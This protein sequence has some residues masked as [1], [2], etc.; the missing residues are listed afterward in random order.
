M[1]LH[2]LNSSSANRQGPSTRS[3]FSL[4]AA[5]AGLALVACAGDVV[6]LGTGPLDGPEVGSCEDG[7]QNGEEA[8]V[9]C[10]G[11]CSSVCFDEP[12]MCAT[13]DALEPLT[14]FAPEAGGGAFPPKL[15]AD[16]TTAAFTMCQGSGPCRAYYWT[17][18][19]GRQPLPA[20]D[21][22][23]HVT[24]ISAD[25]HS[26]LL[27]TRPIGDGLGS[28]EVVW[29]RRGGASISTGLLGGGVGPGFGPGT[30]LS[31]DGS[32]VIGVT[33]DETTGAAHL[34]RWSEAGGIE[35]LGSFGTTPAPGVFG[36]IDVKLRAM[37]PDASLVVGEAQ[38]TDS[39]RSFRWT[40]ADGLVRG[41]DNFAG[42]EYGGVIHALSRDGSSF[43]GLAF[44]GDT[45][46]PHV[47][48]STPTGAF[49]DLG[50]TDRNGSDSNMMAL[51]DDGFVL[52]GTLLDDRGIY[53][54]TYPFRSTEQ[55]G[56]QPLR[57]DGGEAFGERF[58]SGD[59]SVIVGGSGFENMLLWTERGRLS[60][61]GRPESRRWEL[62]PAAALSHDGDVAVG[63]GQCGGVPA[64]Y[65]AVLS[66]WNS[67]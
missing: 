25:G 30:L 16:G 55:S 24:A 59:G 47:F 3:M 7:V 56:M 66:N 52:A 53:Q 21:E 23:V 63:M 11:S 26:M 37:T 22:E 33:R 44:T 17:A 12:C 39:Q 29:H 38:G 15:S 6:D 51:S 49:L 19:T 54:G 5:F 32:V 64:F 62:G 40:E 4:R 27:S 9:D 31:E 45:R 20:L 13:S 10:G 34:V 36:D 14:C 50:P 58:I 67:D 48:H 35:L 46:G 57:N 18:D 60:L 28:F 8:G 42:A 2:Q 43:A 65:R 41:L 1:K 61:D